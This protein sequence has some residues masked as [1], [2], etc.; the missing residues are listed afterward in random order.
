MEQQKACVDGEGGERDSAGQ[1]L[2]T[3]KLGLIGCLPSH[4][5]L[6]PR[7]GNYM[8][9]CREEVEGVGSEAKMNCVR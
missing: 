2:F 4:T 6:N 8:G 1:T 7:G 5:T 9:E 3:Q